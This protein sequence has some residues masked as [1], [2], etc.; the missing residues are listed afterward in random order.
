MGLRPRCWTLVRRGSPRRAASRRPCVARLGGSSRSGSIRGCCA[1]AGGED[2]NEFLGLAEHEERS[3][4]D[5]EHKSRPLES[6][7]DRD[8]YVV[9]SLYGDEKELVED[10]LKITD[11]KHYQHLWFL[12]GRHCHP[13]MNLRFM[14][15]PFSFLFLLEGSTVIILSAKH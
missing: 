15:K 12:S 10:L 11:K 9:Q 6:V 1:N 13:V 5:G 3:F 14:L 8:V 4:E 7:R 2:A